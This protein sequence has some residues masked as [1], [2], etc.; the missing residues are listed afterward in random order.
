MTATYLS[1]GRGK[2]LRAYEAEDRG[3][4]PLSL[5]TKKPG[6][7]VRLNGLGISPDEWHHTG[8]Y[9]K[10]TNYYRKEVVLAIAAMSKLEFVAALLRRRARMGRQGKPCISEYSRLRVALAEMKELYAKA[11]AK[12]ND[13]EGWLRDA[14]SLELRISEER[15]SEL[16][17]LIAELKSRRV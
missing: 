15:I 9:A 8:A 10:R 6:I 5:I 13:A 16:R 4:Y 1:D 14:Y 2:S 17:T 12:I 3:L 11:S 7:K